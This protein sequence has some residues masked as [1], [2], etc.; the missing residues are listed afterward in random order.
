MVGRH[1][2]GIIVPTERTSLIPVVEKHRM[3]VKLVGRR[4]SGVERG[5]GGGQ[6]VGGVAGVGMEG[7]EGVL[8]RVGS[9]VGE[10][11]A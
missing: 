6:G 9:G 8:R 7:G 1:E 2:L 3:S 5:G 10:L 11:G 4:R